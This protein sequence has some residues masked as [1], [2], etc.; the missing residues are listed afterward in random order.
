M[1]RW[2]ATSKTLGARQRLSLIV[3]A[4]MKVGT[5]VRKKQCLP[6]VA[7]SAFTLDISLV[8]FLLSDKAVL[9]T[10][11]LSL[12]SFF[13]PGKPRVDVTI[14]SNSM[15]MCLVLCFR[16]LSSSFFTSFHHTLPFLA[17]SVSLVS[18]RRLSKCTVIWRFEQG[19]LNYHIY[20]G[21]SD[22]R[23][24]PSVAI[25]VAITIGGYIASSLG[26]CN[27]GYCLLQSRQTKQ[28]RL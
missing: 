17:S 5:R 18:S 1:V 2:R 27:G 25:I 12:T 16:S 19:P 20:V 22:P 9:Q 28:S 4:S 10:T 7:L 24:H 6:C 8:S 13:H 11:A 26:P 3:H 15:S 21:L 14:W 23:S